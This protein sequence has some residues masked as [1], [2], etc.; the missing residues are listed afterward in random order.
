M[1]LESE[2]TNLKLADVLTAGSLA[3][4]CAVPEEEYPFLKL[5][6]L[7]A[8]EAIQTGQVMAAVQ[9]FQTAAM[10]LRA[11]IVAART[12]PL[13]AIE[14]F[15]RE[16]RDGDFYGAVSNLQTREVVEEFYAPVVWEAKNSLEGCC[17]EEPA[18]LT[19]SLVR[20]PGHHLP[21]A[22]VFGGPAGRT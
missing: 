5:L 15:L 6:S 8:R 10:T 9:G 7:G 1:A 21:G 22:D 13:P 4:L 2:L 12:K 11:I 3:D 20:G 14:R 16:L 17:S 18:D 19:A